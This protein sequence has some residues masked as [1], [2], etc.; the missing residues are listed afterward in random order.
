M[1]GLCCCG[2]FL[3][4]MSLSAGRDVCCWCS[5]I[6]SL[7]GYPAAGMTKSLL[8]L[9][10]FGIEFIHFSLLLSINGHRR[11]HWLVDRYECFH[12]ECTDSEERQ[13]N[14]GF[15]QL[16]QLGYMYISNIYL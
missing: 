2:C 4:S 13:V 9:M 1:L 8:I 3:V 12:W 16:F 7:K 6:H 14:A 5:L 11:K 10:C 15:V